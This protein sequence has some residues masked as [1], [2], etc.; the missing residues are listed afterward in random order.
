MKRLSV[1]SSH[2][3]LEVLLEVEEVISNH[4][5]NN[6]AI[7]NTT[8][9]MKIFLGGKIYERSVI[10]A[11]VH[12]KKNQAGAWKFTYF[13]HSRNI[14]S[15]EAGKCIKNISPKNSDSYLAIIHYPS[16]IG[17]DRDI[18]D[19]LIRSVNKKVYIHTMERKYIWTKDEVI[20]FEDQTLGQASTR[21]EAMTLILKDQYKDKCKHFT[22]K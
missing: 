17:Y 2:K 8:V 19:F 10:S 3:A 1:L 7:L 9:S 6:Q 5:E 14:A 11:T 22:D 18:T 16:K 21:Q 12:V 15:D 20:G 13:N 4:Q